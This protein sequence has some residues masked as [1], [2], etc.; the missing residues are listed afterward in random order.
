VGYLE[1]M[2]PLWLAGVVVMGLALALGYAYF[3]I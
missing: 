2:H 1:G 3:T